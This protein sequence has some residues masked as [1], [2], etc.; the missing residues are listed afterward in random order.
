VGQVANLRAECQSAPDC[1]VNNRAQDA[2]LP[3]KTIAKLLKQWSV[4]G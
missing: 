1:A 3:H 4:R 2:I